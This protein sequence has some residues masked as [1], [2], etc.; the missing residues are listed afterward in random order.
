MVGGWSVFIIWSVP[1]SMWLQVGSTY[2]VDIYLFLTSTKHIGSY[3]QTWALLLMEDISKRIL[4]A[5]FT[6]LSSFS[7][8][9]INYDISCVI[10]LNFPPISQIPLLILTLLLR[11]PQATPSRILLHIIICI[12]ENLQYGFEPWVSR[13]LCWL[14]W[15]LLP[16]SASMIVWLQCYYIALKVF[17]CFT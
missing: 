16:I 14:E 7:S 4:D 12:H 5:H 10:W 9:P 8:F 13:L 2:I 1:M 6:P 11:L 15:L 17:T 3:C